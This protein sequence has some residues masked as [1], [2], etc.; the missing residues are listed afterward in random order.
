MDAR[1]GGG[2]ICGDHKVMAPHKIGANGV[3]S[4]PTNLLEAPL[5]AICLHS[6][7]GVPILD[8]GGLGP[9]NGTWECHFKYL[10]SSNP[11]C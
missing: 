10:V 11:K 4:G 9:L 6:I 3:H 8:I 1:G 7:L 5:G 2:N